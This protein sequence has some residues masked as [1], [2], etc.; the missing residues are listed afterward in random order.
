MKKLI[1][2]TKIVTRKK[3]VKLEVLDEYVLKKQ[4]K[5]NEFFEGVT[6]SKF[7]NDRDAAFFLYESTPQDPKYRKLKSRFRQKLLNTIFLIEPNQPV[8]AGFEKAYFNCHKEWAQVKILMANNAFLIAESLT[9][10]LL[11]TAIKFQFTDIALNCIRDLRAHAARLKNVKEFD[12]YNTMEKEYM[13]LYTKELRAFELHQK[14]QVLAWKETSKPESSPQELDD[15]CEELLQLSEKPATPAIFRA[16]FDVWI[17]RYELEADYDAMIE[18]CI[19]TEQYIFNNSLY[20]PT[21][22]I[23]NIYAKKIFAFL[24]LQDYTRGKKQAEECLPKLP[25]NSMEWFGF[26]EGYLLLAIHSRNFYQALAIFNNIISNP[27]FKKMD[28]KEKEKW[29]LFNAYL[30]YILHIKKFDQVLIK[31][32]EQSS[33]NLNSYLE[34]NTEFPKDL[35]IFDVLKKILQALFLIMENKF[36]QAGETIS[37][38]N[39]YANHKLDKNTFYRSIQ[40]IKLLTVLKKAEYKIEDIRLADKYYSRLRDKPF[41]YRS[42]YDGLEIL[43]FEALWEM[44]LEDLQ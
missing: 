13:D 12:K 8:S 16:L 35:R 19:Q 7:K 2:I 33:F 39:Y 20:F 30:H 14:S 26:M 37:N 44:V 43:P 24:H 41:H 21:K 23:Y 34:T 36:D 6:G 11:S 42:L 17:M 32:V 5:I 1:E 38:L 10:H 31:Q 25:P 40:F 28:T 22:E 4:S 9:K 29:K 15:I 27:Q 18:V 3:V